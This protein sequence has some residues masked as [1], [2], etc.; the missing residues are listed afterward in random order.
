MT[1]GT[2]KS[3]GRLEGKVDDLITS[4]QQLWEKMDDVQHTTT[5]ACMTL[6]DHEKRVTRIEGV[7]RKVAFAAIV[8]AL[9]GGTGAGI[10]MKLIEVVMK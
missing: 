7:G 5:E 2:D 4:Q 10:A 8:I 3:I 6:Q 1:N 9:T